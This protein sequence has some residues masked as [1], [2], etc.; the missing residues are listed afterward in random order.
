MEQISRERV[1]QELACIGFARVT[2][3]LQI[4]DGQVQVCDTQALSGELAGAVASVERG[5]G[6]VKLKFYDKLKA[7]ELLGK[8][9]SLFDR[10]GQSEQTGLL[11]QLLLQADREVRK[12]DGSIQ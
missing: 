4:V 12:L 1:L 11:E 10:E 6:G 3:Y 8:Y 9:L 2:D 7:L 5:T